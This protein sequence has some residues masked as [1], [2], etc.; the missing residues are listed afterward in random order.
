MLQGSV[1]TN[2]FPWEDHRIAGSNAEV[3]NVHIDCI[4]VCHFSHMTEIVYG[5]AVVHIWQ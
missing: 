2:I 1:Y 4:W 3:F 5:I